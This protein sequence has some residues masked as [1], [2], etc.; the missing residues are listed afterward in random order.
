MIGEPVGTSG[1]PATE[2]APVDLD[3]RTPGAAAKSLQP[4]GQ[5]LAGET[6]AGGKVGYTEQKRGRGLPWTREW[7][8]I[9]PIGDIGHQYPT[10]VKDLEGVDVGSAMTQMMRGEAVSGL[11]SPKQE[12]PLGELFGFWFAHE[13]FHPIQDRTKRTFGHRRHP[14]HSHMLTEMMTPKEGHETMSLKEAASL[15][16]AAG[17]GAQPGAR[18]V[19]RFAETGAEVPEAHKKRL[20]NEVEIIK[21]WFKRQSLPV[22]GRPATR[23]D[24]KAFVLKKI[25]GYHR[26]H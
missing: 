5:Y 11:S 14:V 4:G 1:E 6:E 26:T 7:R 20:E 18:A 21:R 24:V 19:T 12:A 17:G 15:H 2:E 3:V 8:E 16:P 25:R 9:A 22:L 13:S 23:D 10:I